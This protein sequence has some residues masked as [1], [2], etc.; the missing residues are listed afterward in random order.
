MESDCSLRLLGSGRIE[1]G[2]EQLNVKVRIC[3]G[4]PAEMHVGRVDT[5]RMND[6]EVL[7]R[8]NRAGAELTSRVGQLN[9]K[10][11]VL[12]GGG[13]EITSSPLLIK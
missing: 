8:D 6:R 12:Q 4:A 9:D 5:V 3:S 13:N 1:R 10:T 7:R 11:E 2:T